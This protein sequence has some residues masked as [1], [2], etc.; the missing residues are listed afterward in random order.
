MPDN[1]NRN[2]NQRNHS[3]NHSQNNGYNYQRKSSERQVSQQNS[4]LGLSSNV[5]GVIAIMITLLVVIIVIMLFAKSLFINDNK[6][7]TATGKIT[8]TEYIPPVTTTTVSET[9][10]TKK[11]TKKLADDYD[12]DNK[13]DNEEDGVT[14]NCI[15][16]VYLH[17]EPNSSS[18]N[19]A[20]IPSGAK[21]TFYKNENGWY[22]VDY[23]GTKGYA[24][25]TFFD[26]PQ[27]TG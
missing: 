21:C 26:A 7:P 3:N 15:S 1:K 27:T 9:E 2:N 25:Y 13:N 18:A 23:N 5:K 12:E 16:P 24:W 17:P 4:G 22:Y 6:E 20:T 8:S 11:S 14:V 10:E 19:L